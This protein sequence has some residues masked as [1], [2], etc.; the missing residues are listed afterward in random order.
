MGDEEEFIRNVLGGVLLTRDVSDEQC[1][2]I[3]Q[4]ILDGCG[5]Q[6]VRFLL[7]KFPST[8]PEAVVSSIH[9]AI[10]RFVLMLREGKLNESKGL[11]NFLVTCAKNKLID[12]LR[13]TKTKPAL[14]GGH[15]DQ[16]LEWAYFK[17][18]EQVPAISVTENL[19][20]EEQI[21]KFKAF[22]ADIE[23]EIAQ[24]PSGRI[25]L[26]YHVLLAEL[27]L[28]PDFYSHSELAK[29]LTIKGRKYTGEK[30]R[31]ARRMLREKYFRMMK[32]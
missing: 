7:S 15:S 8:P 5:K 25:P 23:K 31:D 6:L 19:E 28:L 1:E 12:R 22:A 24:R 21:A 11:F 16:D 29:I 14:L 10:L 4:Q 9:D 27:E 20:M 30:I 3:A 32:Q 2:Q 18:L 13:S 26:Y 17:I